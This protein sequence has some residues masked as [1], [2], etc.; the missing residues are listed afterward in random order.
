MLIKDLY[1][2]SAV[3]FKLTRYDDELSKNRNSARIN[4]LTNEKPLNSSFK[5]KPSNMLLIN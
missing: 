3:V 1:S 5:G 2:Q 4:K